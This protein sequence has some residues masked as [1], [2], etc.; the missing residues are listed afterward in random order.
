MQTSQSGVSVSLGTYSG[1]HTR[2]R[3]DTTEA[4]N[5]N[6]EFVPKRGEIIVYSDYSSYTDDQGQVHYIPGMKSG[7]AKHT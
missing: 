3:Y 7:T 2:A 4:W 5:N 6:P 1:T